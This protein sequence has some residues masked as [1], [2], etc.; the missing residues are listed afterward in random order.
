M[1]PR[2]IVDGKGEPYVPTLPILPDE[3][4]NRIAVQENHALGLLE[5]SAYNT[6]YAWGRQGH[7]L[8]SEGRTKQLKLSF[9]GRWK[10]VK[11]MGQAN[12]K[13]YD[14]K[15]G[16]RRRLSETRRKLAHLRIKD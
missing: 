6:L 15:V 13:P 10:N 1:A 12:Y 4:L 14:D 9:Y 7:I 5:D 11:P 8:P 16:K 3:I 2:K